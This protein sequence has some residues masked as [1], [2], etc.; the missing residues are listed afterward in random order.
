MLKTLLLAGAALGVALVPAQAALN[1]VEAPTGFFA[2][3]AAAT[4]DSPY[5]RG[6]GEGW[7]WTHGVLGLPTTSATLQISAFDVDAPSEQDLI[8]VFDAATTTWISLGLL[9][10]ANNVYA[11]T[12]FALPNAVWDDITTGLQVRMTIDL[13]NDGWFVTL[14]KSALC[15]DAVCTLN[16]NPGPTGVP[17]PASFAL[18]GLGLLGLGVASR[19][20]A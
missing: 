17:V 19:K 12:D 9:A 1:V 14:A 10:G 11:F 5:Y 2:P 20:R 13:G 15:T 7:G 4:F 16:P 8:E 6:N 18:F 3:G